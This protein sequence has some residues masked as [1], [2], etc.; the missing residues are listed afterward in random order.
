[1]VM[2]RRRIQPKYHIKRDGDAFGF[3]NPYRGITEV[4]DSAAL[5]QKSNKPCII[6]SSSNMEAGRCHPHQGIILKIPETRF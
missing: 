1:M 4:E 2:S 5:N 3:D 6:I